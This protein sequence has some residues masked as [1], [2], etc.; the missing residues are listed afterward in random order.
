MLI[1]FIR[2]KRLEI[3]PDI[4]CIQ[5]H[6]PQLFC[7][8][9][10]TK[11]NCIDLC[12]GLQGHYHTPP[13]QAEG[14]VPPEYAPTPGDGGRPLACPPSPLWFARKGN[15]ASAEVCVENRNNNN[16]QENCLSFTLLLVG[17]QNLLD[18]S[19]ISCYFQEKDILLMRSF[20]VVSTVIF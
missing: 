4:L 15:N 17:N 11:D 10:T 12:S 18:H 5:M 3:T 8:I 14:G 7:F 16:M 13:T 6:W 9:K 19:K 2:T 1:I 20:W